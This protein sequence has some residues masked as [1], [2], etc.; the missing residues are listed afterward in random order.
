MS[1]KISR[2]MVAGLVLI[3][4]AG[5]VI[6]ATGFGPFGWDVKGKLAKELNLTEEQTAQI[7]EKMINIQKKRIEV[8]AK[9]R[10]AE[11]ELR[12]I[13]E[14]AEPDK[15]SALKKVEELGQLRTEL[16]KA[17]ILHWIELRGVLTPEQL[18]K[19]EEIKP[20][21]R[22]KMR[23]HRTKVLRRGVKEQIP[24]YERPGTK[25]ALPKPSLLRERW[26]R[27]APPET[28]IEEPLKEKE[29]PLLKKKQ[30]K[31]LTPEEEIESRKEREGV[32]QPPMIDIFGDEAKKTLPEPELDLAEEL[33]LPPIG[34]R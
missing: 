20:A 34:D 5:I 9:I 32:F 13:L 26:R 19:W 6:I 3:G 7:K 11:L 29:R 31:M 25:P 30:R 17:Q 12:Q 16:Q 2:K 18:K 15:E 23:E 28:D 33:A 27:S 21:F 24:A 1:K 14:K 22:E 10:T 8:G 4:L